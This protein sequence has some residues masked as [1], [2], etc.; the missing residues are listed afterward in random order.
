MLLAVAAAGLYYW[1]SRP[2]APIRLDGLRLP[3]P[4]AAVKDRLGDAALRVAV[5]SAFVLNR[6]LAPLGLSVEVDAGAVTLRGDAPDAATRDEAARVAAQ[7]P[8]VRGVRNL[9]RIAAPRP[10][11][12]AGRTLGETLDDEKLALQVRLA[13]SLDRRLQGRAIDVAVTRGV[14]HLSGEVEDAELRDLARLVAQ[15]V[16]GVASVTDSLRL[17]GHHAPGP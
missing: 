13:F 3:E 14:A 17:R 10:T 15:D 16:P 6:R 12:P 5:Q 4:V 11:Q 2:E 1:R 8:E 7:V 9:V